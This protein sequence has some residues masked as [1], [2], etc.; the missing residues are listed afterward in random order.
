[1]PPGSGVQLLSLIM[2][3]TFNVDF[4]LNTIK[5]P[6]ESPDLFFLSFSAAWLYH[7]HGFP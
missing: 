4:L 2:I 6:G 3:F 1:M 5:P 7:L